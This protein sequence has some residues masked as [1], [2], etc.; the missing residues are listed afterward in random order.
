MRRVVGPS[1]TKNKTCKGRKILNWTT[2]IHRSSLPYELVARRR[3]AETN[4]QLA[5]G[6]DCCSFPR[7]KIM[8]QNKTKTSV[9]N[10]K[11]VCDSNSNPS[12]GRDSHV[13]YCAAGGSRSSSSVCS[14]N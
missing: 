2:A 4:Q 5:R 8:I 7:K 10:V 11:G 14:Q 12:F 1:R 6:H 9:N 13:H 3:L